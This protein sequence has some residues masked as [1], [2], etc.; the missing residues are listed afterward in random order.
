MAGDDTD[1]RNAEA[2]AFWGQRGE[3]AADRAW[4]AWRRQLE[5]VSASLARFRARSAAD[6]RLL[7]KQKAYAEARL[8]EA[9]A[10]AARL[11][12]EAELAGARLE[13]TVYELHEDGCNE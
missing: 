7:E 5:E 12:V 4:K 3:S 1:N 10:K 11:A 6:T 9:E 13:R 8:A 2:L